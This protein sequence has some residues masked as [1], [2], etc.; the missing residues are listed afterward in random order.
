MLADVRKGGLKRDLTLAFEAPGGLPPELSGRRLYQS[1]HGT[2]GVSDPYWSALA[3]YHGSYK[4]ARSIGGMPSFKLETAD[5][6]QITRQAMPR[7]YTVAPVIAKMEIF[8]TLVVRDTHSQWV[9]DVPNA[10]GDKD[11]NYL[12]HMIY[13]PVVTLHNPYNA[14]IEFERLNLIVRDVPVAFNF[15][16]NGKP[17]NNRLVPFNE[18]FIVNTA[19]AA[20]EK[21]FMLDLANWGY[22]GETRP[23]EP[24]RM[25]PGQ[26]L[27]CG[28]YLDPAGTSALTL[29]G[30]AGTKD[31]F[32]GGDTAAAIKMR[33]GFVGKAVG[34]SVDWLTP[35]EFNP[36]QSSD[37]GLGVLGLKL[38][39]KIRVESGIRRPLRGVQD[40]WE[41]EAT[42]V[43][44]NKKIPYG[45]MRFQY[46]DEATLLKHFDKT[47]FYPQEGSISAGDLYEPYTKTLA[48]QTRGRAISS[49]SA[50]P[51]TANG[52]VHETNSRDELAGALNSLRDGRLAGKPFLHHNPA[53]AAVHIDLAKDL[54]GRHTHELNL[55][56][57]K[58]ELDDVLELD[59]IHRGPALTGNTTMK[60]IKS[61]ALFD[62]PS[63]PLQ[64]LA[65]LR[66]SNALSSTYLP[67]FVQPVGNSAVSPLMSTTGAKLDGVTDYPL[68]DHSFLANQ[69]LYDSYYFSTLAADGARGADGVFQDFAAR[70][71]PLANQC[72]EPALPS[73]TDPA[74]L[75]GQLFRSGAPAAEAWRESAGY[76]TVK[77]AFNVNST[78]VLAWK[79]MLAS[80]A[81]TDIPVL[82]AKSSAIEAISNSGTPV[83]AMTL[84]LG[85]LATDPDFDPLK[86]DDAR[87]NEWNGFR[88]LKEEQLDQLARDIVDEVKA[89]GPFLSMAEFVNRRLGP[90][91]ELTRGGA[92]HAALEKSGVNREVF[93]EMVPVRDQDVADPL[94]YGYR[95]PAAAT[96]N[97]AEGAPGWITQGDLLHLLEPRAT[98][99][100]D[101]FVVRACGQAVDGNGRVIAKAYAEA[102][103][104]R[105][106]GYIDPAN[107][108]AATGADLTEVN[109][110]FG[111]RFEV[112]SFRWLS[113]REI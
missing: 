64:T 56:P 22:P 31:R 44:K 99:R 92:L 15:Q 89:R 48:M 63:G 71:E 10:S 55:Q 98:V 68:L 4:Q 88:S 53:R 14:E 103:V 27:V 47:Y 87:T 58:G 109:R 36:G 61:G 101:S 49:F 95:T 70:R 1:T 83:S 17:Q 108:A 26:T 50:A 84:P 9:K 112:V 11:R 25:K 80:L 39:D 38:D 107:R 33:P 40:H 82:W 78:S 105:I 106:P 19:G 110:R 18:M 81:G 59:A 75:A 7:G 23:S 91:S 32:T 41:V 43:V 69:A 24:L 51:R 6:V 86:I 96:G 100:P 102:V 35:P 90:D 28:P 5:P 111:R 73:G 79:A 2:S 12:L 57:L 93:R 77:G 85:G 8:F 113:P 29:R 76:L 42:L 104:Q 67:N 97:P 46:G 21:A 74:V 34:I 72:F 37:G 60:G 52:G 16:V 13:L 54:P 65:G 94:V 30:A 62:L 45:G 20:G 3:A 66:R